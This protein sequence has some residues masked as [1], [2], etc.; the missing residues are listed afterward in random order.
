VPE[1]E[2]LLG[3]FT[4]VVHIRSRT[5]RKGQGHLSVSGKAVE[6]PAQRILDS[7]SPSPPFLSKMNLVHRSRRFWPRGGAA[8]LG[9]TVYKD[10]SVRDGKTRSGRGDRSN[11]YSNWTI[12]VE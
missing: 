2:Q 3:K 12:G 9:S 11:K 1:M 10:I 4:V 7:S 8:R 6:M 5:N